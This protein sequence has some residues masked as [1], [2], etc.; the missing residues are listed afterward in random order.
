MLGFHSM[1]L[2]YRSGEEI[3]AGDRILYNLEPGKIDF[4]ATPEDPQHAWYVEQHGGGCMILVAPF[5][6]LFVSDPQDDEDLEFVS[7]TGCA[8]E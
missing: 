6:S 4:V 1:L 2:K 7:R 5:G 3:K 8:S